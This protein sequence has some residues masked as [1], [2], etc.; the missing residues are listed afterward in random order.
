MTLRARLQ[1]MLWRVLVTGAYLFGVETLARLWGSPMALP[2][3]S[4]WLLDGVIRLGR[5][6]LTGVPV[7]ARPT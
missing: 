3:P 2:T 7:V 6:S 4:D 1:S 5:L